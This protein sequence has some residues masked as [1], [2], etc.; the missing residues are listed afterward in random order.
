MRRR[1]F[2]VVDGVYKYQCGDCRSFKEVGEY[3]KDKRKWHGLYGFCKECRRESR[4]TYERVRVRE[5]GRKR[6][7]KPRYPERTGSRIYRK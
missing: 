4:R 2:I 3:A 6:G 7:A 1:K 5:L